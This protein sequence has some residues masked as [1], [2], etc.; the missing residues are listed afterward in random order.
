MNH[1]PFCPEFDSKEDGFDHS[2]NSPFCYCDLIAD[3]RSDQMRADYHAFSRVNLNWYNKFMEDQEGEGYYD[4]FEMWLNQ[5]TATLTSL[6]YHEI[7]S[8]EEN[9]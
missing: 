5:Y 4:W 2:S 1:D 6:V 8:V 7:F 9:V 3:V